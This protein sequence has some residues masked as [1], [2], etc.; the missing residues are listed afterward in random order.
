MN[1]LYMLI[2]VTHAGIVEKSF[3]LSWII[4]DFR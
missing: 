4:T 3:Y 2:Y 1:Q